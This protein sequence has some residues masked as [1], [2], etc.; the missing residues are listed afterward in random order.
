MKINKTQFTLGLNIVAGP[1]FL[2]QPK[3]DDQGCTF[4]VTPDRPEYQPKTGVRC[5]CKRGIERDNCPNCEATGWVI[6][7]KKIRDRNIGT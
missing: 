7:F 6:D 1:L 2:D 5:S 4:P 3:D